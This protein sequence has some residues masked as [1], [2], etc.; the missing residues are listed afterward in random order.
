MIPDLQRRT[1]EGFQKEDSDK[2]CCMNKNEQDI[3]YFLSFCIEQYMN[4]KGLNREQTMTLF[5][6]YDILDYLAAHFEI[7]HTQNR[8]WIIEDIDEYIRN[9]KEKSL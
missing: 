5:S 2:F 6:E 7:L 9:R 3:A 1:T 4:D 8:Q